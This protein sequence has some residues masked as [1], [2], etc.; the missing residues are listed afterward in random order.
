MKKISLFQPFHLVTISPW[1]LLLSF[2]VI[3]SLVGVINWINNFHF[4]I[5]LFGLLLILLIIF[6]WWR[7]VIRE[8]TF[9][10]FHTKNV[11]N[12]LKLGI[13]LFIISEV[14]FFLRIFWCYFH[15]F[16][17]PRIEIGGIW[18][19]KNI[20][21]FNPYRIPLLNTIILLS[22]GVSVTWCHYSLLNKEKRN[23]KI[24]II[25]TLILGIFFSFIQFIE[26]KNASFCISDSVFGSIFFIST[27]F[28][29]L[30]VL[31]GRI[32]L[33]VNLFRIINNNFSSIH[34]FGFEAA[35]W[36][37]HFV[38]VVWL[39]LYLLVYFWSC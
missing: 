16:L 1:P 9:Q 29:G 22:S 23:A 18:P 27:G 20:I 28:H 11:V 33:F 25:I 3:I 6:Q 10:G 31:I 14:F 38:D 37:W 5:A 19:P 7:D 35:A 21:T 26:Y 32:F 13:L 12:G 2:R 36:Y 24:S 30:H 8:R 17:S 15:I 34:H 4:E 39:F